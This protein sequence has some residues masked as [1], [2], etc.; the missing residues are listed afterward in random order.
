MTVCVELNKA[1]PSNFELSFPLLPGQSSL[2]ANDELVLNIH[3]AVLPAVNV[4]SLDSDWQGTRRK[5]ASS[6]MEFEI[7]NI[8]FLVDAQFRNWLLLFNWMTYITNNKDKMM[9]EHVNYG[10]DST[11][12]M[13][14]NFNNTIIAV[15]FRGMWPTNLQEVSFSQKEGEV[16]LE[17]GATFVFDYFSVS[18]N[19]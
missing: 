8:Q 15:N 17:G 16:L 4:P 2:T 18:E 6:P 7:M 1:S 3:G 19:I 5:L 14:D 12:R 10:I 13:L 11:L 9:D